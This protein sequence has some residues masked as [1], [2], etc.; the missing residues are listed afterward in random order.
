M[1]NENIYLISFMDTTQ[2]LLVY[3]ILKVTVKMTVHVRLI[4]VMK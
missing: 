3:F 4:M 1:K 2:V